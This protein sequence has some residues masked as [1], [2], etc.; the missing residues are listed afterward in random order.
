MSMADLTSLWHFNRPK[1]AQQFAKRLIQHE[2]VAMFGPRQTGKTTLLREEILP[3]LKAA[4]VLPIYI[5][6]WAD[7][8][9]PLQSINY[10]LK[11]A[12]EA[13]TLS[14]GKRGQRLAKTPIRKIGAVGLSIEVGE[15]AE[16][17]IP[18][19]PYFAFDALLTSL[20]EAC[21]K[22]LVLVFDEFQ[23]IAEAKD[24][25]AIAAALRAALTQASSKVGVVFSGSSQHL[26]LEMF[27]RAQTP[28]YN[29]ANT[30]PYPLLKED[31]VG[32]VAKKYIDATQRDFNQAIALRVLESVGHQPAPF[33]NAVS[34]A[35][36]KPGWTVED[37][38]KV[39][40]DPKVTNKWSSAWYGL[41]DLQRYTLRVAH[42]GQ[43]LT[44]AQTL[45]RAA[46]EVGLPK[47][48]ASSITRATEA[49]M[50]K[51]LVERESSSRRYLISDPVMAAWLN[52]NKGMPARMA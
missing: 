41:T 34:N 39:M 36:S 28:L 21:G 26:L 4:G 22:D 29:F 11:K 24:A 33:L 44:S 43:L 20:L 49:L 35:M 1:L 50:D 6:C 9:N 7:K 52:H 3:A 27:S 16:R 10:A 42:E 46:A 17:K 19:N 51:G 48:Q 32:H 2:R 15:V 38:L 47:V 45:K 25:D 13:L 31:F 30:E 12:L 18:D 40:L 37:G 14:P 5:E 8:A 23:A